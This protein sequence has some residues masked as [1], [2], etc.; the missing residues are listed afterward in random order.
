MKTQH[1]W[2]STRRVFFFS[3]AKFYMC[4]YFYHKIKGVCIS[5]PTPCVFILQCIAHMHVL[6]YFFFLRKTQTVPWKP[7]GLISMS[8]Y[9]R[10]QCSMC[11]SWIFLRIVLYPLFTRLSRFH[12]HSTTSPLM[13]NCPLWTIQLPLICT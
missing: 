9:E 5:F 11:L 13:T 8:V 12:D 10:L 1:V 6:T 4:E 3:L 2:K 7:G